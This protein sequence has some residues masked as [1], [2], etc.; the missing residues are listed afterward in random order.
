MPR[1]TAKK[2]AAARQV[3]P[4]QAQDSAER[5][6]PWAARA[7]ALRLPWLLTVPF[8]GTLAALTL[9]A[10]TWTGGD[11]K[12]AL[13]PGI[14]AALSLALFVLGASP[15]RRRVTVALT[16]TVAGFL[17]L[18]TVASLGALGGEAGDESGGPAAA[19]AFQA[20]CFAASA[21]YLA[22]T[23]PAWRRVESDGQASDQLLRMYEEL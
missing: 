16:T 20:A 5:P 12:A 9:G 8:A 21:V 6:T 19:A 10:P 18:T 15:R 4:L 23:V 14:P 13:L 3:A 1:P 11:A 7:A 22:A 2:L 17:A